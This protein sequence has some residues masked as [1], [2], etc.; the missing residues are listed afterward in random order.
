[1]LCIKEDDEEAPRRLLLPLGVSN[2]S[3][4]FLKDIAVSNNCPHFCA[5]PENIWSESISVFFHV[6][7]EGKNA[8]YIYLADDL[9]Y[10]KGNRFSAKRNHINYFTNQFAAGGMV[11]EP[12]TAATAKECWGCL[13]R[14]REE[15]FQQKNTDNSPLMEEEFAAST[16][17]LDTIEKLDWLSVLVR[18]EGEVCAFA[19]GS[20]LMEGV[21]VLNFE[22]ALTTFRGLY[23]FLDREFA[24]ASVAAG[25]RYINKEN[26][27]GMNNLRASKESYHPYDKL[28]SFSLSL[29]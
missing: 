5:V 12:I 29:K 23:Q 4:T 28:R 1:L 14:W 26:D 27:M 7:D 24:R 11:V 19:L 8:N 10:L 25:Y 16:R 13:Q 21:V 15:K 3:A 9:A 17:A 2:I 22:K 18:V 20:R 6:Q